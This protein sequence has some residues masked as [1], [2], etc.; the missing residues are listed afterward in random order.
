MENNTVTWFQNDV[1]FIKV[2]NVI[3]ATHIEGK[4]PEIKRRAEDMSCT[5]VCIHT[6]DTHKLRI[7]FDSHDAYYFIVSPEGV[8][9]DK[10]CNSLRSALK[11]TAVWE[12]GYLPWLNKYSQTGISMKKLVEDAKS[13]RFQAKK[14]YTYLKN[15]PGDDRFYPLVKK[16]GVG[17]VDIEREE[18]PSAIFYIDSVSSREILYTG[19][20]LTVFHKGYRLWTDAERECMVEWE[21]NRDS[22]AE[23]AD[24]MTDGCGEWYRKEQFFKERGCGHLL[25]QHYNGLV[26]DKKVRGIPVLEYEIKKAE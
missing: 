12:A 23:W 10:P 16:P 5:L 3:T 14:V 15:I 17:S 4:F 2:D 22:K 24:L 6:T 26:Q 13:G 8:V 1:E 19:N 7:F 9:M 25:G 20:K 11:K 18:G 21:K